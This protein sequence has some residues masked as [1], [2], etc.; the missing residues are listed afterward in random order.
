[1]GPRNSR[2]CNGTNGVSLPVVHYMAKEVLPVFEKEPIKI[3]RHPSES[4][5]YDGWYV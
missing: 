4:P 1:M 5:I 2:N 3:G